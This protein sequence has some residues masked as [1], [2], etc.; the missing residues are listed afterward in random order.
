MTPFGK[1]DAMVVHASDPL[2]AETPRDLL[3]EH[4][5]TPED[6]FYVRNHGAVPLAGPPC[7]A[8]AGGRAGGHGAGGAAG[9]P[10]RRR[11][12]AAKRSRPG[13]GP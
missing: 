11:P 12:A 3:A 5:V 7:V 1:H 6:R 8:P 2:N 13:D 10:A 9:G 4:A